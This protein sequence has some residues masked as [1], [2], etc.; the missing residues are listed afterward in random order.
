MEGMMRH[1]RGATALI[2]GS[3]I[4]SFTAPADARE[5]PLRRVLLSTG[6][7]G[8]FEHEAEVTGDATF[9]VDVRLDQVSDV[10]KS[11]VVFDAHGQLGRAT[12]PGR[13]PLAEIFRDLPF[14]MDDLAS[15]A[16]LLRALRGANIRL[17]VGSS[18]VEGRIVSVTDEVTTLG[19]SRNS[20]VR[21]RV[22]LMGA[23][24]LRQ[25]LL[26]D[27]SA[28]EIVDPNLRGQVE[29]A[30]AAIAS[31]NE[32]E[33]R[34]IAIQVEGKGK[35]MVNVGYVVAVPLWKATYRLVL[36]N[37]QGKAQMEGFA[38]LENMSGQDWVG[39]DLTVASGNPVTFRQ[40]L[41]GSYFI[42]R[43]E[44]PV[45]VFGRILPPVDMGVVGA[46][47]KRARGLSSFMMRTPA[48]PAMAEG[49]SADGGVNADPTLA[50]EGATSVTFHFPEP[51]DLARGQAMF[52]P[53][54]HREL[55]A[56]RVSVFRRGVSKTNPMA[57]VRLVND[58]D[59]SLP[60]GAVTMYEKPS[61][62]GELEFV[63]DARLGPLPVGQDRLLEY[64]VDLEV[65]VDV[66]DKAAQVISGAS[67]DRGVL[68]VRRIER[69]QTTYRI[70]G[71]ADEARSM[72]I[73]HPRLAGFGLVSPATGRLGDTPT[74]HRL[75]QEVQAGQTVS[76]EVILQQPLEERISI[77]GMGGTELGTFVSATEIPQA[78]RDALKQVGTLQRTLADRQQALTAL[79]NARATLVTDQ[80]R[81]RA[82]L[83]AVTGDSDLRT[84]YLTALGDTE[85]RIAALDQS[86][87]VAREAVRVAREELEQF[88]GTL[89]L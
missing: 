15:P 84:R 83:G 62:T 63:G 7:V 29:Q 26:E 4:G 39:V 2:L 11:I 31:N 46:A 12:L 73:E 35:R 52:A 38:V 60:P 51:I 79:E 75:A 78:I 25:A 55:Q 47:E 14:A 13:E 86:I 43:P 72:I 22:S 9:S 40:A 24:G 59:S 82:N 5:L 20:L 70:V 41:Y 87:G 23:T 89:S 18:V 6:G 30:L 1:V 54:L 8:Y 64:A 33:R 48:Q 42:V 80:S 17:V 69:R 44:V 81:L 61:S 27:A 56:Q 10:L 58:S 28:I 57:S 77:V 37:Q 53:I 45:E 34:S 71:A 21:H 16:V 36:P 50:E 68:V 66:Q 49:L 74:H 32:R 19:D 76:L 85:D 3:I 65:Q 88:I 67:V